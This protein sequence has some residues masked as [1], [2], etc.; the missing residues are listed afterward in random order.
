M[1]NLPIISLINQIKI[2]GEQTLHSKKK[3]RKRKPCLLTTLK[4]KLISL[5]DKTEA[6]TNVNWHRR[7]NLKYYIYI[8]YLPLSP[9]TV[10]ALIKIQLL[11]LFVEFEP[12]FIV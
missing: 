8:H 7:H 10:A 12:P 3:E 5:N 6:Q 11:I 2:L 9:F 4:Q 1:I